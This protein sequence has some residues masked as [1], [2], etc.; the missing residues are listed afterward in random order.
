MLLAL[1][2]DLTQSVLL[3]WL[4]IKNLAAVDNAYCNKAKREIYMALAGSPEFIVQS[5]PK[6]DAQLTFVKWIVNRG[7]RIESLVISDCVQSL[8]VE[9][10][11]THG[12]HVLRIQLRNMDFVES[13]C[14]SDDTG[15][16][17][18]HCPNLQYLLFEECWM[19]KSI[20]EVIPKCASSLQELYLRRCNE[21]DEEN[22]DL[23]D[24]AALPKLKVSALELCCDSYSAKA[25]LQMTDPTCLRR[26]QVAWHD[27]NVGEVLH[28]VLATCTHLE[29]LALESEDGDFLDDPFV[30]LLSTCPQIQHLDLSGCSELTDACIPTIAR[31]F[32][33]L[34]SLNISST[35]FSD[36][37]LLELAEHRA[38]TLEVLHMDDNEVQ[39][40]SLNVLLKQCH[41]LHTLRIALPDK[42][43]IDAPLL[44][45]LTTLIL[46]CDNRPGP[47]LKKIAHHCRRLEFLGVVSF[48]LKETDFKCINSK[49]FP[50]LRKLHLF[51]MEQQRS[52]KIILKTLQAQRPHLEIM[53][54]SNLAAYNFHDVVRGVI[55]VS[56]DEL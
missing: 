6:I 34:K 50:A 8:F 11:K 32:T 29:G 18:Q 35:N 28:S 15:L 36:T 38:E 5:M 56:H 3:V 37:L 14:D 46:E 52:D 9:Y 55:S 31:T 54:N 41:K 30:A 43:V 19:G 47:L 7:I 51:A 48:T 13:D 24:F 10:L 23:V 26:L 25:L 22:T 21:S 17:L 27:G 16:M 33:Q 45:N 12:E 39:G 42:N 2:N 20:V 4:D 49:T 1:P 53:H 40:E 44:A